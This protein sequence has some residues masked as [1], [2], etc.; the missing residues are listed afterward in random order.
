M[1]KLTPPNNNLIDN[2]REFA[3]DATVILAQP[4]VSRLRADAV[5]V[6][7]RAASGIR[8]N[9]CLLIGESARRGPF[10]EPRSRLLIGIFCEKKTPPKEPDNTVGF[11]GKKRPGR[12]RTLGEGGQ[13]MDTNR[14]R[15]QTEPPR[16][17]GR[18]AGRPA[19]RPG[20]QNR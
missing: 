6:P 19:G 2:L 9:R 18:V 5:Y 15:G 14:E 20:A 12:Q 8:G 3:L 4:R 10:L 1:S 17:A 7:N 13:A 16:L 11:G